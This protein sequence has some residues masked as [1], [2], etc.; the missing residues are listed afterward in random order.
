MNLTKRQHLYAAVWLLVATAACL[1]RMVQFPGDLLV[2]PQAGGQNDLTC[3]VLAFRPFPALG[4]K[5]TQEIPMWNPWSMAGVPWIGNPQSGAL[6]PF[7]WLY[8]ILPGIDCANWLVFFHHWW[9]GFGT[10]LLA[11]RFGLSF[12]GGL[13]AG[14]FSLGAPYMLAQTCEGHVSQ[15]CLMSWA[16]WLW[17]CYERIR[18]RQPGGVIGAA[19]VMSMAFFC[20]H[21]QELYY[22]VLIFS[23]FALWDGF[24]QHDSDSGWPNWRIPCQWFGAGCLTAGM[25]AA[26]LLP[27]WVYLRQAVRAAGITATQASFG[28]LE[29]RSLWQLLD[30]LAYGG[31]ENS[32]QPESYAWGSYW[33]TV[34]YFG[35]G[36]SLLSIWAICRCWHRYPTRRLVGIALIAILFSFA[37]KTPLFPLLHQFVPGIGMFRAPMR[38]LFHASFAIALLGGLGLDQILELAGNGTNRE[39]ELKRTTRIWTILV[40]STAVA[41]LCLLAFLGPF[42]SPIANQWPQIRW[43]L[44]VGYALGTTFSVVMILCCPNRRHLYG[45]VCVLV[46][47][48]DLALHGRMITRTIPP[49]AWRQLNPILARIQNE[50]GQDRLSAPQFLVSDREAW[51][52]GVAK[53]QAY[54]PVPLIRYCEFFAALCP[55]EDPVRILTG[56]Y[57]KPQATFQGKLLDL[58][59]VTYFAVGGDKVQPSAGWKI[60]ERGRIPLELALRGESRAKVAYSLFENQAPLPRA[61]VVYQV[62]RA[63]DRDAARTALQVF[64]PRSEVIVE[65]GFPE[66]LE[67]QS[68]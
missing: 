30:P 35:I 55:K 18:S 51:Q 62:R 44:T 42:Q 48:T 15:V 59:G 36:P 50:I 45:C 26:E 20:S 24:F 31:P 37:N 61:Y 21:V 11:R 2:G 9:A 14:V 27:V 46:C 58:L 32:M 28:A 68:G 47:L 22:L 64:D 57:S 63:A 54:E 40:G 53:I 29:I 43:Q 10:Y 25:V 7:N 39:R 60:L 41:L 65:P 13:A 33:E 8:W 3:H 56:F 12:I 6:Y 19:F 67:A 16:P 17:L 38:A 34:L 66:V 23:Y 1:S 49:N 4:L 5:L 52:Q